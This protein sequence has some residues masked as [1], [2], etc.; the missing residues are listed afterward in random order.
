MRKHISVIEGKQSVAFCSRQP[1]L[2]ITWAM[3]LLYTVLIR[4]MPKG[5]FLPSLGATAL[6]GMKFKVPWKC[7]WKREPT[8][9]P[10]GCHGITISVFVKTTSQLYHS[11]IERKATWV[12]EKH[13]GFGDRVYSRTSSLSISQCRGGTVRKSDASLGKPESHLLPWGPEQS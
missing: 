12:K 7:C 4:S 11:H 6:G 8:E 3:G 1:E 2:N 9:S 13:S 10:N 5:G